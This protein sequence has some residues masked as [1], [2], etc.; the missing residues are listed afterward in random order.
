MAQSE[1]SVRARVFRGG[2]AFQVLIITLLVLL[3]L[4]IV[5][6]VVATNPDYG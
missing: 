4:M 5:S 6:I 2:L 1:G 3:A